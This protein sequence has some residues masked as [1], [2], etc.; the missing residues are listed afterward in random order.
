MG[1]RNAKMEELFLHK[2]KETLP[3]QVPLKQNLIFDVGNV[4]FHYRWGESLIDYGLTIEEVDRVAVEIFQ[5]PKNV[6]HQGDLGMLTTQQQ[7]DV[8]T[9]EYPAD[10]E[11][12]AWF[13]HHGEY[14][15]V[16]R[17]HV[18]KR[19]HQ[20]KMAGY[21]IYLLSNYSEELFAKHTQ[22]A[23]FMDDLDGMIISCREHCTKPS[24]QIYEALFGTYDLDPKECLFFDDRAENIKAGEAFGMAGIQVMSMDGLLVDLDRLLEMKM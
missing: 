8:L 24:P 17:P 9:E 20:L 22:F 5:D 3:H 1:E 2:D 21:G 14:L 7:I 6:W 18:W 13:F 4:L 16:P 10:G 12:L 19:V 11:L 23:E 15:H